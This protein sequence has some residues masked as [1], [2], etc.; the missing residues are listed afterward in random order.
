MINL[1]KKRPNSCLQVYLSLQASIVKEDPDHGISTS[2][3]NNTHRCM[4]NDF[5]EL[6]RQA[7]GLPT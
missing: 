1:Q 6:K 5:M 3:P 7:H 2:K 4:S